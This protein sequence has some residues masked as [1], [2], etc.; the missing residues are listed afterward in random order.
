MPSINK[1]AATKITRRSSLL[2]TRPG[3]VLYGAPSLPEYS[4]AFAGTTKSRAD[5]GYVENGNPGLNIDALRHS[6]YRNGFCGALTFL[7]VISAANHLQEFTKY[8]HRLLQQ[9]RP[10]HQFSRRPAA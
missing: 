6:E 3:S 9:N 5:G 10:E 7:G 8:T 2:G 1:R 4:P